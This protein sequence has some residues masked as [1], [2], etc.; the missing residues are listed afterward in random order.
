MNVLG[1]VL[2][3]HRIAEL[4]FD[5]LALFARFILSLTSLL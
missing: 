5:S 2:G 1:D 3:R 4:Q